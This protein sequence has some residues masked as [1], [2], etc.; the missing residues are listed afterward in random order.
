[1]SIKQ[2]PRQHQ[3]YI[4]DMHAVLM[5]KQRYNNKWVNI[6]LRIMIMRKWKAIKFTDS[7]IFSYINSL[8]KSN[9]RKGKFIIA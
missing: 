2:K 6:M 4:I 1:M 8:L 9:E 3:E 7:L 5:Q